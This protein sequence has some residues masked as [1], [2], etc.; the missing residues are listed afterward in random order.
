MFVI[1]ALPMG[2]FI[3]C[4]LPASVMLG[5]ATRTGGIGFSMLISDEFPFCSLRGKTSGIL[6]LFAGAIP[7][8]AAAHGLHFAVGK[9][10]P[11]AN[12]MRT[13]WEQIQQKIKVTPRAKPDIVLP[14]TRAARAF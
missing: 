7:T 2:I 6:Y 8:I 3:P 13:R 10:S 1:Y 5:W 14:A 9:R 4:L 11:R 12:L